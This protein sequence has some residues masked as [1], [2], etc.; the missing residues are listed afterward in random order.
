MIL[1]M[2]QDLPDDAGLGA[3]RHD[4]HLA[5]ASSFLQINGSVLNTRQIKVS[6]SSA[7]SFTL[8]DVELGFSIFRFVLRAD[9][10]K[11]IKASKRRC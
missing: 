1:E 9:A 2:G 5:A 6:P 11:G 4:A 3:E 7:K 10:N 8:G